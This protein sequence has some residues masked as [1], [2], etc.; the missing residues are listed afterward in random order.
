[1]SSSP[2]TNTTPPPQGQQLVP[3]VRNRAVGQSRGPSVPAAAGARHPPA[4][5][6]A[7]GALP[8]AGPAGPRRPEGGAAGGREGQAGG[9][10]LLLRGRQ[11][12]QTG[13]MLQDLQHLLLQVSPA[14]GGSV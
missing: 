7:D 12:L 1:M 3:P 14:A 4:A 13:G 8:A 2:K 11:R 5:A 9:G 6:A 10:G